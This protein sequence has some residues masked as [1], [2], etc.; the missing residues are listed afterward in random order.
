MTLGLFLS[1]AALHL[2]AAISPGPAVLMAARTG[3]TEGMR[4]GAALAA[5]IGLGAVF[6]ATTA[7]FGLALVFQLAP[8]LLT[9]FKIV[10]GLYLFWL[11]WHMWKAADTP[12]DTAENRRLPR[13][14]GSAFRL[15]LVTQLT[16]PKPA[17]FFGAI[18]VGTVPP[19]T[20]LTIYAALLM[21]VFLNEALW[22]LLV[23]RIFSLDRT[24][25]GYLGLKSGIDRC[26]GGLLGLLGVKIVL[27]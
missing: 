21:V 15:G 27:T 6:W 14:F 22:N 17:V 13:T 7:L 20:S 3:V 9:G 5:G 1:V 10:G 19:G 2:M 11:A 25:R 16:N 4:T 26:F 12:L 18:F 24:K 8:A 23:V